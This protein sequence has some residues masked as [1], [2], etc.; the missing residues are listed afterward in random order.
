MTQ[1][2]KLQFGAVWCVHLCICKTPVQASVG[3]SAMA[4]LMDNMPYSEFYKWLASPT[5]TGPVGL[6]AKLYVKEV[7]T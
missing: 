4:R 5:F 1:S 6:I 3:G 7:T 2:F